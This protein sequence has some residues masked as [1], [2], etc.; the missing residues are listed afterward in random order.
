MESSSWKAVGFVLACTALVAVFA[1]SAF[2]EPAAAKPAAASAPPTPADDKPVGNFL[3][4]C[5]SGVDTA[6]SSFQVIPWDQDGRV[7][8]TNAVQTFGYD[9]NT[10]IKALNIVTI[11]ELNS[12]KAIKDQHFAGLF[13]PGQKY[14]IKNLAGLVGRRAQ[15]RWLGKAAPRQATDIIFTPFFVG[16]SMPAM[17]GS[18]SVQVFPVDKDA[19]FRK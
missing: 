11:S 10:R 14:E 9:P 15:V 3:N 12:G 4:G 5:I 1:L 19:C 13:T 7:W 16:E 17:V 6:H 18:N 2:A 8:R